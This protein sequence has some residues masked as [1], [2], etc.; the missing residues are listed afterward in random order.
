MPKRTD[1]PIGHVYLVGAGPGDP[2]WITLRGVEC[3]RRADLVLYDYLVNTQILRHAAP[4]AETICL[5]QHGSKKLP[6]QQEINSRMVEAARQGRTVVRLK[7]GDPAIFAHLYEET[8]ALNAAGIPFEVVPGITA[9]LALGSCLGIPLTQREHA[10]AVA[11]ITGHEGEGKTPALDYGALASFPG[12]L[13]FYMG[14]TRASEWTSAL[15]ERGKPSATPCAIVRRCSWPDQTALRCT[16]GEV[17][18]VLAAR[19]VRPPVLVVVGDVLTLEPLTT[20]FTSRP[21]FGQRIVVTRPTDQA[22][23]LCD[24]LLELGAQVMSQPA[25]RISPPADWRP[26][27]QALAALDQFD[28]LVF[29][30]ANGVRFF[31]DRL[32]AG[33][34]DL[35]CLARLRLA[36]IG[37]GTSQELARY[38]LRADFTPDEFQA[39]ALADALAAKAANQRFLLIRASRGREVLAEKL[40]AASCQVE[41]VVTYQSSDETVVD[42]AV[43]LALG[44]ANVDWI[45]VSSSAIARSLA[46]LLGDQL[47]T[48]RLVSISPITSATLREL[49]FEPA[50]EAS[51]YTMQGMVNAILDA[52]PDRN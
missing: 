51:E 19:H 22:G 23:D 17:S 8:S 16:L 3:L 24:R 35:R 33:P 29:S 6:S 2:G 7:G 4:T 32:L 21:L 40:R 5:G 44:Q 14:V 25:I 42:P 12:T 36:T 10:S 9:A 48:A 31:L 30:S 26:V 38:H 28:W 49:G 46:R 52:A 15:L 39:E 41:Q 43:Q 50:A 45:T 18:R 1:S 27:D 20:W 47:R 34:G 37:P 13:I 11:L